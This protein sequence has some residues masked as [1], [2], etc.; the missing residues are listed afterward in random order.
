MKKKLQIAFAS[1][2]L[3]TAPFIANIFTPNFAFTTVQAMDMYQ[4]PNGFADL[5]WGE[6]LEAVQATHTTQLARYISG[7]ASYAIHIPDAH[8]SVYF[9]GPVSLCGIFN[10]GKLYSIII[11]FSKELMSDRLAGLTKMW[12]P[13]RKYKNVYIWEGPYSYVFLDEGPKVATVTLAQ[14]AKTDAN[15]FESHLDSNRDKK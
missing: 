6:T 4:D 7:T 1:L 9:V 11:P 5:H 14:K 13:P 2:C 8:G 15:R 10:E 12:G 3:L